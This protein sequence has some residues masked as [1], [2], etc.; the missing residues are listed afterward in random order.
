VTTIGR[1]DD[2]DLAI[3]NQVHQPPSRAEC[4][5]GRTSPCSEDLGSTNGVYVNNRRIS[6]LTLKDGDQVTIGKSRFR[7]A[8][9]P[10]TQR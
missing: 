5:R 10:A 9:K 6:K 4:S 7:F 2:N 1:T 8:L 3:D